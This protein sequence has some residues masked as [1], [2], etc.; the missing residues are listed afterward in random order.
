MSHNFKMLNI[1]GE[2]YNKCS[3]NYLSGSAEA[4]NL[5]PA[6][7]IF[8]SLWTLFHSIPI[9][10]KYPRDFVINIESTVCLWNCFC[11]QMLYVTI[12]VYTS[13]TPLVSSSAA[14]NIQRNKVK[15]ILW[16]FSSGLWTVSLRV[17]VYDTMNI[18]NLYNAFTA[19]IHCMY[20]FPLQKY[21]VQN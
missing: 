11:H 4:N 2:G 1:H 13:I 21:I 7:G 17:V 3:N 18:I 14:K 19:Y 8:S 20:A 10:L 15:R 9:F 12:G 16:A 5:L 6:N